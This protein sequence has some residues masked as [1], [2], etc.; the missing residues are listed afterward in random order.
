MNDATPAAATED[1]LSL[2]WLSSDSSIRIS[3]HQVVTRW[4]DDCDLSVLMSFTD[5][6]WQEMNVLGSCSSCLHIRVETRSKG[7]KLGLVM[8]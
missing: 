1:D 2:I 3:R 7:S 8:S 6:R 4:R 5:T